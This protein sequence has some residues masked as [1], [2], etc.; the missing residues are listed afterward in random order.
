MRG[1]K[2]RFF[3]PVTLKA[4]G[5]NSVNLEKKMNYSL[6][7]LVFIGHGWDSVHI[8]FHRNPHGAVIWICDYSSLGNTPVCW[9]LPSSAC[10]ASELCLFFTLL[11]STTYSGVGKNSAGQRDIPHQIT[12]RSA[13]N[14]WGHGVV[15]QDSHCSE[16]CW[17]CLL[18]GYGMGLSRITWSF[19][20]LTFTY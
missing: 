9:L 14:T 7:L 16:T 2:F 13:I 5:F 8:F 18:L 17:S 12:S 11:P 4:K 20:P 3:F 1:R 6:H 19:Y 15:F 10:T